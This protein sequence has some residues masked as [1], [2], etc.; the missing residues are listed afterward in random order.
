LADTHP[1]RGDLD[2]SRPAQHPGLT[3]YLVDWDVSTFQALGAG[4]MAAQADGPWPAVPAT[5]IGVQGLFK[6]ERCS[7]RSR[8]WRSRG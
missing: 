6:P 1:P 5:A 4:L 8:R 7:S 2:G 3:I